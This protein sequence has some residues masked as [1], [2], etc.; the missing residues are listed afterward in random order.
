MKTMKTVHVHGSTWFDRLNGNTYSTARIYVDGEHVGDTPF[1]Y[2]YGDYYIQA[3]GEWLD[4]ND[5]TNRKR[6]AHGGYPALWSVLRDAG[7]I[8]TSERGEE[9]KKRCKALAGGES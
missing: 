9:L 8:F 5:Y 7:V 2:G 4:A 6:Y 1:E 3:A